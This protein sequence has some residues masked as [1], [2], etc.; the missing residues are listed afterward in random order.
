MFGE[1]PDDGSKG[2]EPGGFVLDY[3]ADTL[4]NEAED[5]GNRPTPDTSGQSAQALEQEDSDDSSEDEADMFGDSSDEESDTTMVSCGR[6]G[7]YRTAYPA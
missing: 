4:L 3:S 6:R 5:S 2:L 7:R 1:P